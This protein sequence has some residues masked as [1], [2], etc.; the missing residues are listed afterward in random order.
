MNRVPVASDIEIGTLLADPQGTLYIVTRKEGIAYWTAELE[1][2]TDSIQQGE[3]WEEREAEFGWFDECYPQTPSGT[4]DPEILAAMA[5]RATYKAEVAEIMARVA[6]AD[7]RNLYNT[8][9]GVHHWGGKLNEAQQ[10]VNT[11]AKRRAD[12]LRKLV[13]IVGS[14]DRAAKLLGINQSTLS[15]A[16]RDRD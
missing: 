7:H 13:G 3:D 6:P 10:Q 14:Q 4:V 1:D 2:V 5:D 11:Y 8:M 12:E 16:L 15:R 9:A